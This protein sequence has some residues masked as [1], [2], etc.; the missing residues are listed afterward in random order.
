MASKF[1]F[2]VVRWRKHFT[3]P[4]TAPSSQLTSAKLLL[5][6]MLEKDY[7][8]NEVRK[9]K[10]LM[11]EEDG[12]EECDLFPKYWFMKYVVTKVQVTLISNTGIWQDF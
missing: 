7:H 5:I 2:I 12:Y 4:E 3:S 9:V 6:I 11:C 10:D 1:E 8:D